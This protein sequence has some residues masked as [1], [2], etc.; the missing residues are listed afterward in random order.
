MVFN[1]ERIISIILHL[2]REY[3]SGADVELCELWVCD[4]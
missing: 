3:L 1:E 2:A 4:Y